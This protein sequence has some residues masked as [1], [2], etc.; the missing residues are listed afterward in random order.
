MDDECLLHARR[1]AAQAV[2]VA[3]PLCARC[4]GTR[5]TCCQT[6]EIHVTAGDIRRI[7]ACLGQ[8]PPCELKRPD[9]PSYLDQGDDPSWLMYVFKPDGSRRVLARREGGD[10]CYLCPDGCLLPL[11]ARPLVCRLYPYT[12]NESGFT[13]IDADRCPVEFLGPGQGILA[14]LGMENPD[15]Y[16]Q[17]RAMLYDEIKTED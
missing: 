14:A 17:W 7:R 8:D 10:C 12:Y 13:G 9:N 15:I 1:S 16:L 3:E 4:A 2:V 6:S 5:K 11:D